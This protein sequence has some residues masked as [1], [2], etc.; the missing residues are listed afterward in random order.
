MFQG[1]EYIYEVYK[2]K[3]FSKAAKN[4]YISQPSLSANVKRIEKQ[5]GYQVFDRST[6]PLTL[7]ECGKE[8]IQAVENMM[9]IENHFANFVND[10][11]N[12]KIGSLMIGGS[13]LL[14][15]WILP[16]LMGKFSSHYPDVKLTLI[17]ENTQKLQEMLLAGK[18]DLMLDNCI[19]DKEIFDSCIFQEEHLILAVPAHLE[20]NTRMQAY[21]IS[22]E[23]IRSREFLLPEI[24]HVPLENFKDE[25]FVLLKPE[26]D[27]RKRAM[28]ICR[29]YHFHPNMVFELDQQMTSY[30]L[31]CSGMGISFISDTLISCVPEMPKVVYYK[32]PKELSSRNLSFYWKRGRYFKRTMEE[33]LYLAK[34]E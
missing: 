16:P 9:S 31:T 20:V 33:F 12:L 34:K 3:S 28:E 2:E 29:F 17:E 25:L 21:Q 27:T 23:K 5:I 24:L 14:A 8:Y 22:V 26:N 15:S 18:L 32:L 11:G 1:K 30:N 13:S 10:W 19:L 4:L 6:K 7:T